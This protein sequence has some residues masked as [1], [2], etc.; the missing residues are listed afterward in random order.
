M[1]MLLSHKIMINMRILYHKSNLLLIRKE[2]F[3]YMYISPLVNTVTRQHL[4][5]IC[6]RK[7][8]FFIKNCSSLISP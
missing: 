3:T 7:L 2:R 8:E 6:H 5:L 1:K 4:Y